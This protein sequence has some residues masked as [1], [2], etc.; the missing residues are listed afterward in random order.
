MIMQINLLFKYSVRII[1][2]PTILI[3]EI[4]PRTNRTVAPNHLVGV[5]YRA[6]VLLLLVL[7]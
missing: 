3:M 6:V 2:L 5:H 4:G 1:D 7:R